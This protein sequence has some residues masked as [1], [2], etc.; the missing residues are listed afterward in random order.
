MSIITGIE[1]DPVAAELKA[2]LLGSFLLFTQTFF[3]L[4]TG[5]DFT[6]SSPVSREPHQITIA[7]QLT[8]VFY[9]RERRVWMTLPPGHGK[10]TFV[11][12]FIPWAFAHYPDCR[13][14]YISYSAELAANHTSNIKNVMVF[15]NY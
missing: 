9:M 15:I 4:R 5:R 8:D 12:Y 14:I 7:K 6:V 11:S 10:S 1:K 13:F 3:K 2:K